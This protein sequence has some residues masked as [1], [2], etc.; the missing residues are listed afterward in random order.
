MA[1]MQDFA[2]GG[3]F[4]YGG[5][6]ENIP[7]WEE[8]PLVQDPNKY[9]PSLFWEDQ[10]RRLDET[11]WFENWPYW[12]QRPMDALKGQF[13]EG[14]AATARTGEAIRDVVKGLGETKKER[15]VR[16]DAERR[17]AAAKKQE[18]AQAERRMPYPVAPTP[19]IEE[20]EDNFNKLLAYM[21]IRDIIGGTAGGDPPTP[22]TVRA[23]PAA[24]A[25][26]TMP[27]MFG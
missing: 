5:K 9:K 12:V 6:H 3:R 26:P 20:D 7:P 15:E 16:L 18:I 24:R 25:F 23:G 4:Y 1:S 8:Q 21:F 22:Y 11:S 10:K 13:L 27:S 19:K 14:E 17:N 2:P